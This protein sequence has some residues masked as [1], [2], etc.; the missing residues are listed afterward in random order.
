MNG[1]VIAAAILAIYG[2]WLSGQTWF[3]KAMLCSIV[4][5]FVFSH[6]DS[7]HITKNKGCLDE[8]K[9]GQDDCSMGMGFLL[10]G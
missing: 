10:G 3:E 9:I 5:T 2:L 8:L 4:L 7:N 6:C 1:T